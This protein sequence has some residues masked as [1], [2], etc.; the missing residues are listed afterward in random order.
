MIFDFCSR[1]SAGLE[2]LNS[3]K[4]MKRVVLRD[5]NY[6]REEG[7]PDQ[8]QTDCCKGI[9]KWACQEGGSVTTQQIV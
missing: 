7:Y 1:S 4:G 5:K 2:L 9:A 8:E 3:D 6:Q